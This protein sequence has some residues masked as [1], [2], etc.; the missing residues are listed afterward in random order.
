MFPKRRHW[1]D[2]FYP[3]GRTIWPAS[4]CIVTLLF[5]LGIVIFHCVNIMKV[6]NWAPGD[7]YIFTRNTAAGHWMG[8]HE[9]VRTSDVRFFPMAFQEFNLL[10][11]AGNAPRLYYAIQLAKYL[12]TLL[13]MILILRSMLLS[14]RVSH[15]SNASQTDE[16]SVWT[17]T[18][19]AA[20]ILGV[21][22]LTQPKMYLAFGH[23]IYPE[24]ML[25]LCMSLFVFFGYQGVRS[26]HAG[27]YLAAFLF[28]TLSLYY[29]EPMF[30]MVFPIA[31]VPLIV[32]FRSMTS[33][34]RVFSIS[35]LLSIVLW[36]CLFY[37]IVYMKKTGSD[38]TTKYANSD[39]RIESFIRLFLNPMTVYPPM[40]ALGMYRAAAILRTMRKGQT[41]SLSMEHLF[42]DSLLFGG[43]L[44]IAAFATLKMANVRFLPPCNVLFAVVCFYYACVVIRRKP[45]RFIFNNK[46]LLVVGVLAAFFWLPS[47]MAF[48]YF[49]F[50][51]LH[52]FQ[53]TWTPNLRI[54]ANHNSNPI[55]YVYPDINTDVHKRPLELFYVY[56]TQ[57][58]IR[59]YMPEGAEPVKLA[60][61]DMHNELTG[62]DTLPNSQVEVIR[63]LPPTGKYFLFVPRHLDD[64]G[65]D[66][67]QTM[68]DRFGI[69]VVQISN[70]AFE[71]RYVREI[72]VTKDF[73]RQLHQTNRLPWMNP[74]DH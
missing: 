29:K 18:A 68:K 6:A 30:T 14:Q 45:Q 55:I 67:V 60:Y 10:I 49:G 43:L 9:Q 65:D 32:R 23:I 42:F 19:L 69:D 38:Y 48:Q 1:R 58:C 63:Q 40:A 8:F 72:W 27:Y 52:N 7:D 36:F 33:T 2:L 28:G 20:G 61:L 66:F 5:V 47:R 59:L 16:P 11:R 26:G 37:F 12:L 41:Q 64:Y 71:D 3:T 31:A 46:I 74:P 70:F 50:R 15:N 44:Y 39:N 54:V 57:A 56:A 17:L 13:V 53:R 21:V 34:Q 73:A 24:S 25:T 62:I 22:F 51:T 35:L 4:I